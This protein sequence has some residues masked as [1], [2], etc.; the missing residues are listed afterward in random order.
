MTNQKI[1]EKKILHFNELIKEANNLKLKYLELIDENRL[2][3][4]QLEEKEQALESQK[5]YI[6]NLEN[7]LEIRNLATHSG[8]SDNQQQYIRELLVEIDACLSLLESSQ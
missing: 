7:Q 8:V 4:M 1:I 3:K 5:K 2:L 6:K